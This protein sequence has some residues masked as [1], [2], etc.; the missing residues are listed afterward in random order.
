MP[1]Q[2]EPRMNRVMHYSALLFKL[3][4]TAAVACVSAKSLSAS[5]VAT[6]TFSPV[7]GT[8]NSSQSVTISDSTTG[9]TIYYTTNG[10]T[11]TTSSTQ[12]TGA[13][14]VSTTET[15]KA[16]GTKSGY[17]NS[18]V[19]SAAYTLV[20]ATPTFSPVAGTY[21]GPQSVT[22]SDA[23][24]GAA[25]Y[26]T[27]NGNTPTTS[28]THYTGAITVSATETVK[29]LAVETGYTNSSVGSAAYTLVVATPT[30]L[31]VAGTYNGPQSVTISDTTTG[32]TIY[33][34][35]NGT[36]PTTN[37]VQ[38]SSAITVSATE[39]V[40]ALG[41]ATGYTNSS[42]GSAAYTINPQAST[43]TFSP[44]AGTYN[45]AVSVTISDS[46]P[47]STIYY[48]TN[49]AT[50]T[51]SSPVYS[52]Q[53]TVS[54][55][56]T[57]NAIATAAGYLQSAVGAATY[58]LVAATPAFSPAGGTYTNALSVV[59]SDS[60]SG[61]V[62]Y[63]TT[64]GTTPTTSSTVYSGPVV[65]SSTETLEAI[66]TA[67]GYP[68]S[69]VGSATYTIAAPTPT[70]SPAA[71]TY[72]YLDWTTVTIS[73]ANP[74]ATI[75]YTVTNGTSGTAP[76]TSSPVYS[77]PVGVG[78]TQTIEAMAV[79]SGLSNSAVAT[80]TYTI[81]VAPPNISLAAGS[82]VGTQTV[83]L[84]DDIGSGA[85]IY[86]TTNGTT[87]TT[88][89]SRYRSAL[90]VSS[91]ETIQAIAT[92]TGYATSPV[93]S[94]T[95]TITSTPNTPTFSPAGGSYNLAQVVSIND[96]SLNATIYYTVTSGT[97]GTTPTT[98]SSAYTGAI[99][100]GATETL[101][102]IAYVSGYA[103]SSV[104]TATYTLPAAASTSTTLTIT[105]QG[106]P[107]TS[108]P[109]GAAI[110]LTA[111]VTS[112]GSAV[113]RGTVEFCDANATYCEDTHVIGTAQLT[114]AGTASMNLIPGAGAHSYRAVMVGN[115]SYLTSSSPS[116]PLTVGPAATNTSIANPTG[117]YAIFAT[118]SSVTANP[119]TPTGTV[120]FVDTSNNN[121]VLGT[122]SLAGGGPYPT[123]STLSST[124]FSFT[125]YNDFS[126]V[127]TGDFNGD[128]NTDIAVF[129]GWSVSVFL[130]NG[131]GSFTLAPNSPISLTVQP[132]A[133]AAGDFN[134]DGKLDLA[135]MDNDDDLTILLGNGDGTFSTGS[136]TSA[137]CIGAI[138]LNAADF[139]RDGNLD[140]AVGCNF[141]DYVTMI[142]LGR[143]DG[144]FTPANGS[145]V[146]TRIQRATVVA[147]FNGDGIPDIA[148]T[149]IGAISVFL[150]N[151]D[152]TFTQAAG[153]PIYWGDELNSIAA[154][155]LDGD[156]IPDLAVVDTYDAQVLLLHGNGDGTFS[157]SGTLFAPSGPVSI[158]IGDF[159]LDGTPDLAVA[160]E[161][162]G[163]VSVFLNW[164]TE[165]I[166][167]IANIAANT[168]P[169]NG[170]LSL[171]VGNFTGNGIPDIVA[172]VPNS[173][174][175]SAALV[176][177][178]ALTQ[179]VQVS[180]T[181]PSP[182]GGGTHNV[183]AVYG[184][185]TNYSPSTSGTTPLVAP[186]IA[187]MAPSAGLP[188]SSVTIT[189][190]NFGDSQGWST[191]TFNGT[192]ASVSSWSATS[193]TAAVPSGATTGNVV[194][195]VGNGTS[196]SAAFTVLATPAIDNLLPASGVVGTLVTIT[197]TNFGAS[198][199][200]STVTFN[201]TAASVSSWSATSITAAVPS[202]ATTG[203][204]V[205][206]VSGVASNGV[207]FTVLTAPTIG[208][209]SPT[210]GV[211][212]TLVTITGT[213]FGA[214]Q[215]ASTV[216]FNGTTASVS[217][218]SAT[219]ITAAVPSGAA[220]GNVVVTV[221]GVASNSVA[222]TVLATAPIVTSLN[223]PS[224]SSGLAARISGSGFG[225]T[226]GQSTVT[227]NGAPA[228][229]VNW[230][231]SSITAF[232]P[233]NAT[234]GPVV[235]KLANGQT[236]NNNVI[237][238]VNTSSNQSK[239]N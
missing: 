10:T 98:S 8:Y 239:C 106:T 67:T 108:A 56:E 170:P 72:G 237:F 52:G 201:G 213:N 224:G 208:S 204:V 62:I 188:G 66:A 14:T 164:G 132:W 161:L 96:T 32:A 149:S 191:V 142:L 140:L 70:F 51:T 11:P 141:G 71:G 211:V 76:T 4:F 176:L 119:I 65:V 139:N 44:G 177:G 184:G 122:A 69:A 63:Y 38:Y 173:A 87:P 50:P 154:A 17:T 117:S 82:Y 107:V 19:G 47:G 116:S 228:V 58:T 186:W 18:S 178:T 118:V 79:V 92:Y 95:Y 86:Y 53:I 160:D 15:I 147:D 21:N 190:S 48:T 121:S 35:T 166:A 77:G 102:A 123:F 22:I 73:D 180:F 193:I 209:L 199:G 138:S 217:S 126:L 229:V 12:Y 183:E 174:S 55:T 210:S 232:V 171:G 158:V 156:G 236:S 179:R 54:S 3:L 195:T 110:T 219:S 89:S 42:V 13:I 238:T 235:V 105:S 29:A 221:S 68:Q 194:V 75:Y 206:T 61:A 2:K 30:F 99:T 233:G 23:T 151:G 20:V 34:T 104:A 128:G 91:S 148:T 223:P 115:L 136:I 230:N 152:G 57:L 146:P 207:A 150:G 234:T 37:S 93:S 83:T 103:T 85:T 109:Q 36:T 111:H 143:G 6:P 74:N 192:A 153:S 124:T 45:N 145:P 189:G 120:S 41:V 125:Q 113:S 64:D 1:A 218:W 88:S 94:A 127:A 135:V 43:P 165:G 5:T 214:S 9:A 220:T 216:T 100:V 25:I 130:G 212:G 226:E 60:T 222:F 185:D 169:S 7:A 181:G 97:T 197:G 187:N 129:G 215:G 157:S 231:N 16:I 155:D 27:T 205:V 167:E 80:A 59:L 133:V 203:N 78:P 163:T 227:F 175:G 90:T 84:G 81:Q 159:N 28:S 112:G 33:Y 200:T 46:T 172:I 24:S 101:E 198:Q 182:N 49:G 40:E 202:G 134:N 114:T 131:S 31:P 168:G 26:Y 196:N 137:G 162:S 39:T 144:T 225:A